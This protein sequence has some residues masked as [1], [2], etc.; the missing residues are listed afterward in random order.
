MS[1]Q[2]SISFVF[3]FIS[4]QLYD[5]DGKTYDEEDVMEIY[6]EALNE[7]K[8]E[9]PDFIGSKFIY[10]PLKNAPNATVEKY[11]EVVKRLHKRFPHFLA[12]FDLV[13]QEDTS[14]DLLSFA[15]RLLDLP[16]DIKLFLHAGETNWNGGTDENMVSTSFLF[17]FF[18]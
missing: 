17:L 13:G 2:N 5:L 8:L 7:F 11:F 9:N 3:F 16:E 18:L 14:T 1:A 4:F 6:I 10:A 12:G 15:G